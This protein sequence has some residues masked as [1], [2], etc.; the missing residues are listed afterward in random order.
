MVKIG[1]LGD[2]KTSAGGR[3][4]AASERGMAAARDGLLHR[5]PRPHKSLAAEKL[6]EKIDEEGKN[7]ASAPSEAGLALYRSLVKEA[8]ER[9]VAKGL[10]LD[11]EKAHSYTSSPKLFTIIAKIDTALLDLAEQVRATQTKKMKL[12]GIVEEIKGLIA[13]LTI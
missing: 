6:L 3:S 12:L 7:F 5:E 9:A 4:K 2:S 11:R 1:K 8:I 10:K 13:N